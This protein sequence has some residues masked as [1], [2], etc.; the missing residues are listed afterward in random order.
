MKWTGTLVGKLI[1]TS[2]GE[3]M[4]PYLT[5]RMDHTTTRFHSILR[6][7]LSN[8]FIGNNSEIKFCI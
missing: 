4:R 8:T 6:I 5:S 3:N 2:K 7:T 1:E